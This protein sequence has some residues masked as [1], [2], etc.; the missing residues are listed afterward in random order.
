[1]GNALIH[2]PRMTEE[3]ILEGISLDLKRQMTHDCVG[4]LL[5]NQFTWGYFDRFEMENRASIDI[6]PLTRIIDTYNRPYI[7]SVNSLPRSIS[8]K[9]V[10]FPEK[11][12]PTIPVSSV[13]I[14][15][16]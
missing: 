11:T 15:N 5:Y 1:M 9:F 14:E 6:A 16:G 13:C 4:V 8:I 12:N 7:L 3:E 2:S 10:R